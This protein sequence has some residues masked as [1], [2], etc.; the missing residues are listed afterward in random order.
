[1]FSKKAT[2]LMALVTVL[3]L[4]TQSCN[5]AKTVTV[6]GPTLQ[7]AG[8]VNF[9]MTYTGTADKEVLMTG[10][11]FLHPRTTFE[12]QY[13]L[14]P[15]SSTVER[16]TIDYLVLTLD[17]PSDLP[18]GFIFIEALECYLVKR[19]GSNQEVLL[20]TH[21]ELGGIRG[22]PLRLPVGKEL[23]AYFNSSPSFD[24][25]FKYRMSGAH[26]ADVLVRVS[27]EYDLKA[28]GLTI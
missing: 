7:Q 16:A 14:A 23:S 19:D 20:G 6:E 4:V 21:A 13:H 22:N 10:L 3:A 17:N 11:S 27:L 9:E 2:L 5:K 26:E 25:R 24:L 1:M 12:Q 18:Y 15:L 28:T 8:A